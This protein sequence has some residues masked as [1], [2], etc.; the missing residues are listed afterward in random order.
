MSTPANPIESSETNPV[1]PPDQIVRVLEAAL[2]IT[3]E[4]L[5]I[6]DLKQLFAGVIDKKTLHESLAMLSEKWQDSGIEL[7]MVA[8]GWR[9]QSKPEMQIFLDRLNPQQPPRYSRAV[10]ETLAIIAYRQPVTRG[11]IEEIRGVAVSA[12]I[13]KTLESRGWIETIGQRDI[14]GRPY[15]YATSRQFLDDLNLLSLEQLPSLKNLDSLDL[16][17]GETGSADAAAST[18]QESGE[19]AI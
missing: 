11:D 6:H 4:P 1:F 13:I 5:A 15:L 9:F 19:P 7:V 3:P 18:V 8:G 17:A 2:L 10:M 12:Q 16:S 14:P